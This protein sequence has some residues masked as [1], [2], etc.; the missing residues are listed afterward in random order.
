MQGGHPRV[1]DGLGEHGGHDVGEMAVG[2]V[3]VGGIG[4]DKLLGRH[5][6]TP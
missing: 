5:F 2:H 3:R 6:S 4:H 1:V